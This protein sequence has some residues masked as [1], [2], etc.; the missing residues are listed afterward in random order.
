MVVQFSTPLAFNGLERPA[1]VS[2]QGRFLRLSRCPVRVMRERVSAWK[3]LLRTRVGLTLYPILQGLGIRVP[4]RMRHMY[5]V[6][7]LGRAEENYVPSPYAGKLTLFYGRGDG[8]Q[9]SAPNMG[10]NGL[11][12]DIET[13][14]IGD[15]Q[16]FSRRSILVEPLVRQLATALNACLDRA[17]EGHRTLSAAK[18][19]TRCSPAITLSK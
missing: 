13:Y 8:T 3:H 15:R 6:R 14:V 7:M 16:V 19:E 4:Q 2:M 11:A 10:W 12:N 9:H 18:A 1:P 17:S 5:V